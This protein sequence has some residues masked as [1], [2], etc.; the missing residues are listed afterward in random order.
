MLN[1]YIGM[2]QKQEIFTLM[3]GRVRMH[4]SGYNPTS[5]AVWL[6][7]MAADI[8]AK[9]VLDVGI[10]TGGVSLCLLANN[11]DATITGIDVSGQMLTD[12][13]DN[14]SLNNQALE[15]IHAD[16][17]SWRTGRTFDLV[18]SNPP[19]FHGT[20]AVHNAH[21]NADLTKWTRKCVARVRPRG[22]FCTIVDAASLSTVISAMTHACGDIY[23]MPLFGRA[24]T[25]ERVMIRGRVG[26][27]GGTVLH[28]GLSMNNDVVLR[29][30][31]TICD[32]LARLNI[33]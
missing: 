24:N 5:D 17:T 8:K 30:G 27:R 3:G 15:L 6:A 32:A 29:D 12:C 19:Y 11:R 1:Y 26:S 21:H 4:R 18:V 16:I 33:L 10:G 14:A 25:A 20:P 28:R 13:A 31:L 7:A 22:Y 23:I 9:T 2:A